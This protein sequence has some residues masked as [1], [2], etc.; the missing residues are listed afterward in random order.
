MAH[1]RNREDLDQLI[2]DTHTAAADRGRA[3]VVVSPTPQP[4]HTAERRWT[5]A[6]YNPDRLTTTPMPRNAVLIIDNAAAARPT[7]LARIAEHAAAHHARL[8]LVDDDQ[9]GPSRRLLDGLNLPWAAH[10]HDIDPNARAAALTIADPELAAEIERSRDTHQHA[11]SQLTRITEHHRNRRRD[12]GND[13][14]I[15]I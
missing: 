15:D 3:V 14:G 12:L 7:D 2:T 8:L 9:P 1:S 4:P 10:Q 6:R 13:Y 5:I 11:W